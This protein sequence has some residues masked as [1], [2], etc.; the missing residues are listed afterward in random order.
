MSFRIRALRLA[1]AIS[2]I[3]CSPDAHVVAPRG[4]APAPT[5]A[6]NPAAVCNG[7]SMPAG[8]C[9]ALVAL[10]NGTNGPAWQSST[11]WGVSLNP[12]TWFGVTCT[13]GAA[14]SV[15]ELDLSLN[16]LT[17]VLP[18]AIGNLPALE[19]IFLQGNVLTGPLPPELGN[20]SNLR[21]LNVNGNALTG[22]IPAWL[23]DIASLE[24]LH[25]GWNLFTGSIPPALANAEG[26]THLFL[27]N[28]QLS[29]TIPSQL[30]QLT[31]LHSL[32]LKNN[33][34]TGAIPP[35]LGSL[36][37]LRMLALSYNQLSGTIPAA[38]GNIGNLH[39]LVLHD[40]QLSGLVPLAF[41]VVGEQVEPDESGGCYVFPGNAGLY[42]PDTPAYRAADIYPD[43]F[44]CG[45]PFSPAEDI[46]DDAV[47]AI[48]E[49]VPETLNEGQANALQTKIENAM[50]KAATGQFA[51]AINQLQ[52]FLGQLDEMVASGTLTPAQAAPFIDQAE[53]LIAIWTT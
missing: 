29:G 39:Q 1:S 24:V 3:G 2:L 47:D 37:N 4:D 40:N 27:N 53:S 52:A 17:G 14:G 41:A 22:T 50:A 51:A 28:N 25:L 18:A 31:A 45:I 16:M 9:G 35:E 26:L 20:L 48:E 8:E 15:K 38:L 32:D 13:G 36:T 46:G 6:I 21:T 42:M 19:V 43:G 12:C 10:Y 7:V 49:L 44:I 33:Q 30:G 23:G 34:L 11:N 5:F